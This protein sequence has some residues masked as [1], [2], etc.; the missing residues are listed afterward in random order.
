MKKLSLMLALVCM[1]LSASSCFSQKENTSKVQWMSVQEAVNQG[2]KDGKNAKLIFIDCYTSWCGW[3]KVLDSKSFS[4]DTIAAILNYYYYPCKFDAE[5]KDVITIGG[6][7]YNP[8]SKEGRGATHELMKVIWEGQRGGG[9]PTMS[10]RGG[11]FR[12]VDC[13]MG[14]LGPDELQPALIYYAEGYN[15]EMSFEKFKSQYAEKYQKDVV[16]KVLNNK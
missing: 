8:S 9:Y 14:F 6:E 4:N 7:T 11:D 13:I 12:P 16:K 1:T 10:I 3:C 5:G 2:Q 15:K